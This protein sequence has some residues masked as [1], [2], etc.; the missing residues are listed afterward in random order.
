MNNQTK[1]HFHVDGSQ[2]ETDEPSLTGAEIKA[3]VT[4][5]NPTYQLYLESHG[6][7]ADKLI[8]DGE[9]V[10]LD[11]AHHGVRKFYSVPPATF[12]AL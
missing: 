3:K 5:F 9:T 8:T 4:G 1:F 12:G 11:P 2:Y 7:E 6:D 10:S